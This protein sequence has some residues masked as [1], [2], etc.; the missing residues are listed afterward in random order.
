MKAVIQAGGKGTRLRPFTSVLP[1]PLMPIGSRPVLEHL[2]K[3]LRR[4]GIREVFITTGYLGHLIRSFCG[5]GRQWDLEISY[6]HEPEPLGTVGP[7][8]LLEGRLDETFL[9]LN[10][11]V[12]T[13]LNL[14]A[15]TSAH[16]KLGGMLTIATTTRLTR[17]DYGVIDADGGDRIT[18]FRE[19][20]AFSNRVS[21]GAYCL[22]PEVLDFIP[23]D[24]AFGVDDLVHRLMEENAPVHIFKHTGLWLDIG[25]V[26]DFQQAQ[27]IDWTDQAPSMEAVAV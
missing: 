16:R 26:D 15:F 19:K 8:R 25:R 11:D 24:M 10:G 18:A 27:E 6:T 9:V 3:W 22:E 4:N 12:L 7:L 23:P 5:D 20:P 21:M 13:D 14:R 2:L 1:K 17:M